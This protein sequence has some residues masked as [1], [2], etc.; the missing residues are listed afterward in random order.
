[1]ARKFDDAHTGLSENLFFGSDTPALCY[2]DSIGEQA[3]QARN[4]RAPV[5]LPPVKTRSRS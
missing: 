2:V 3:V 4:V 5:S 1:M